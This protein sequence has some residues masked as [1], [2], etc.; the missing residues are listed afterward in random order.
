[1]LIVGNVLSKR[2]CSDNLMKLHTIQTY[3]KL[4]GNCLLDFDT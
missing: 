3:K 4:S 2:I 1:M